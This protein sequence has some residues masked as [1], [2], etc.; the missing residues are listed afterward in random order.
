MARIL[1]IDDSMS[2][3][4]SLKEILLKQFL[5]SELEEAGDKDEALQQ[6]ERSCPDLIFMDIRLTHASGLELTREIKAQCPGTSVVVLTG[7]DSPEYRKAATQFGAD[8]FLSKDSST[9]EEI[10]QLAESILSQK[11]N[12]SNDPYPSRP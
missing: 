9:S 8:H 6:V 12:D 3:R 5:S 2:F 11:R 1:I 10:L 7:F 4:Q